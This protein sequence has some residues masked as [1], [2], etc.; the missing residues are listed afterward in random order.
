MQIHWIAKLFANN[1]CL[2]GQLSLTKMSFIW[3]LNYHIWTRAHICIPKYKHYNWAKQFRFFLY[4]NAF[5]LHEVQRRNMFKTTVF[6]H[7]K[8]KRNIMIISK[9]EES[10]WLPS[11]VFRQCADSASLIYPPST[12]VKKVLLS[13]KFLPLENIRNIVFYRIAKSDRQNFWYLKF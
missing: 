8:Q 9:K 5:K 1:V 12:R 2:R 4:C 6:V 3:N 10:F 11:T 7:L 13:S